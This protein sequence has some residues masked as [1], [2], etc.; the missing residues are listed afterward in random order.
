MALPCMAGLL[1]WLG[2]LDAVRFRLR[3]TIGRLRMIAVF[4]H[5]DGLDE[6]HNLEHESDIQ[7]GSHSE[8]WV[9]GHSAVR[10]QDQCGCC[11]AACG[12]SGHDAATAL[13]TMAFLDRRPHRPPGVDRVLRGV[14]GC[15]TGSTTGCCG[16][17]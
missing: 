14:Y 2:L 1:E 5:Y 13:A 11:D 7:L 10:A 17:L 6:R 9:W 3:T 16:K 4:R 8:I 12:A 15:S